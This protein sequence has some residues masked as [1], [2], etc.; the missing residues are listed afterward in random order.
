MDQ[1]DIEDAVRRVVEGDTDSYRLVVEA[2]EDKVRIVLAAILPDRSMVDDLAQEVFLIA[3]RKI[4][5]YHPNT[6]FIAWLKEI[7]RNLAL[8]ERHQWIRT[9]KARREFEDSVRIEE[10]VGQ[11]A[12]W[13]LAGD[14]DRF[15]NEIGP[16]MDGLADNVRSVVREHYF[17][18]LRCED[19]ASHCGRSTPWVRLV[20]HRARLALAA[21]L[22]SKGDVAH[23]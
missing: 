19:I 12:E 1:I 2:C 6:N 5:T 9:R 8:H 3:Y 14:A 7:A 11:A 15:V 22:R 13:M 23:A 4:S 18:G 16:C 10:A 21:C 20:L 17:D